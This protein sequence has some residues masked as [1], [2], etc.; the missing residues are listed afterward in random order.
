MK[1]VNFLLSHVFFL[2]FSFYLY[3]SRF[4]IHQF[5]FFGATLKLL[6][7]MTHLL[8]IKFASLKKAASTE[9][10]AIFWQTLHSNF[11][12]LLLSSP[13][14]PY[15]S[16][17][18]IL[19]VWNSCSL[20]HHSDVLGKN[21]IPYAFRRSKNPGIKPWDLSVPIWPLLHQTQ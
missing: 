12:F 7:L 20:C 10:E 14:I 17:F 8:W 9:V 11:F 5:F 2:H 19:W 4:I 6:F 21:L 16:F 18:W 3:F 15:I 13:K 1:T